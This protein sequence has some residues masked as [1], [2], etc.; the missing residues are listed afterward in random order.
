MGFVSNTLGG[1]NAIG[2]V[3]FLAFFLL[4][5]SFAC[6]AVARH[7]MKKHS[8]PALGGK[9]TSFTVNNSGSIDDVKID[10]VNDPDYNMRNI[11]R[12]SVLLEEHLFCAKKR[13]ASCIVKH[14]NHIAGLAEEAVTLAGPNASEFP[15]LS[16]SP[17]FYQNLYEMWL[18]CR[19]TSNAPDQCCKVAEKLRE[20]RRE[21][22][23]S[24]VLN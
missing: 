8:G 5:A 18:A 9:R 16:E 4:V 7:V 21:L 13:C 22:T 24:Y 19:K 1:K 10:P 2:V 3:A 14:F 12:Q 11:I 20:R 15:F 6:A 23:R 17:T